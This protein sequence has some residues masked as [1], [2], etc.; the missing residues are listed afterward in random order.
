MGFTQGDLPSILPFT[1]VP[2]KLPVAGIAIQADDWNFWRWPQRGGE[3][4]DMNSLFTVSCNS[5]NCHLLGGFQFGGL[6]TSVTKDSNPLYII[7]TKNYQM[8]PLKF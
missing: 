1:I 8:I 3:V 5:C 4:V 2:K 6:L 7:P